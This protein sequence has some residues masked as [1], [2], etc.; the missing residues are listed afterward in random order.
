M[1]RV[2][3]GG[4]AAGRDARGARGP[5]RHAPSPPPSSRPLPVWHRQPAVRAC[6]PRREATRRRGGREA[7][8]ASVPA[9]RRLAAFRVHRHR[10][11]RPA[12]SG[13]S[14]PL[15]KIVTDPNR[16]SNSFCRCEIRLRFRSAVE[17]YRGPYLLTRFLT[18]SQEGRRTAPFSRTLTG[19]PKELTGL[20]DSSKLFFL[21]S[22]F[23]RCEPQI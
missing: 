2:G 9:N 3:P 21:I 11:R 4:G 23:C 14:A 10:H 20:H 13:G 15:C 16:L 5:P 22:Q 8:R 19:T 18:E 6:G 12:S 1:S 17:G 7:G